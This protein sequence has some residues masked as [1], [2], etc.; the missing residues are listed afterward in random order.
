MK[1][2]TGESVIGNWYGPYK[3][4]KLAN[5]WPQCARNN[6]DNYAV[7][8]SAYWFSQ[9]YGTPDVPKSKNGLSANSNDNTVGD[10][11]A[12]F[13]IYTDVA[14]A[15]SGNGPAF[16]DPGYFP[17]VGELNDMAN[18]GKSLQDPPST[19]SAIPAQS[20]P[21]SAPTQAPGQPI[22]SPGCNKNKVSSI[23]K[24]F[25][26]DDGTSDPDDLL[27]RIRE[28]LCNNDCS[29]PRG[30]NPS[31]NALS[32]GQNS[33]MTDCEINI[34][35]SSGAEAYCYRQYPAVGAE[36]QECWD[37]TQSIIDKCVA[38]GPN[39][40]WWNG[41]HAYQFNKCG[42]RP[43]NSNEALYKHNLQGW[44]APKAPVCQED[45]DCSDTVPVKCKCIC[46]CDDGTAKATC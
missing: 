43:L 41:D 11:D 23:P 19:L 3:T 25:I 18:F 1:C 46:R 31:S 27:Y 9:F 34:A 2:D 37:S 29:A 39:E 30:I 33:G 36:W 28:K 12:S 24:G 22:A 8:A 13:N 44:L 32:I 5:R 15:S 17:D 38:Q 6:A 10:V 7:F 26:V 16:G 42:Y 21:G 35:V 4:E 45:C 40:G 20:S 14:G